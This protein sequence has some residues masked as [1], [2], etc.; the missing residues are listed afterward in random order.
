VCV[1]WVCGRVYGLCVA[2]AVLCYAT[3]VSGHV[4]VSTHEPVVARQPCTLASCRE[5][6][7]DA[8]NRWPTYLNPG[9]HDGTHALTCEWLDGS[10]EGVCVCRG[11]LA[12]CGSVQGCFD[13]HHP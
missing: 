12:M 6:S 2:C 7:N 4:T 10:G 9:R 1:G 5:H 11:L 8:A 3:E 13:Q